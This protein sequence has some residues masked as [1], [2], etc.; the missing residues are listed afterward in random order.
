MEFWLN[1]HSWKLR[2][3]QLFFVDHTDHLKF[4]W[5]I[6]WIFS[7]KLFLQ[8]Q[9]DILTVKFFVKHDVDGVKGIII[10]YRKIAMSPA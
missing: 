9:I 3:F 4:I 5:L 7:K 10:E 6:N 1:G 8:I 2:R